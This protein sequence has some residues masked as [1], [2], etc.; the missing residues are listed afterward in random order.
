MGQFPQQL[1]ALYPRTENGEDLLLILSL[2]IYLIMGAKLI[3]RPNNSLISLLHEIEFVDFQ[4]VASPLE[5]RTSIMRN[6][7][8]K[9][10]RPLLQTLVCSADVI[11]E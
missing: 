5:S 2:E 9:G 11:I 8:K 10:V 6:R 4:V 3:F 7:G 1:H